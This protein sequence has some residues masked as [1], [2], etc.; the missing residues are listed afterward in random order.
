MAETSQVK[1]YFKK[2]FEPKLLIQKAIIASA[3]LIIVIAFSLSFYL[4][5][6]DAPEGTFGD[7]NGF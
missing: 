5:L 2:C 6:K 3:A 4:W 1:E 7:P